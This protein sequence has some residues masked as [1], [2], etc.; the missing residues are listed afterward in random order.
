MES[1]LCALPQW[2]IFTNYFS[3][4]LAVLENICT[5]FACIEMIN[6]VAV[7]MEIIVFELWIS[8]E[9]MKRFLALCGGV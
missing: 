7:R 3:I 4:K 5:H 6:L 1:A 8:T 9:Q 2:F